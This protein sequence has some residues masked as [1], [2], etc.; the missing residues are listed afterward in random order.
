MKQ[1]PQRLCALC[2]LC[3]CLLAAACDRTIE[4]SA[5]APPRLTLVQSGLRT[6]DL[7]IS[8]RYSLRALQAQVTYDKTALRLT[9]VEPGKE[10]ERMDRVFFT[11]LKKANGAIVVG[12]T[13]TRR[14]LLPARGAL[15]RLHFEPRGSGKGMVKVESPLGALD[16]GQ[17]VGLQGTSLAVTVK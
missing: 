7:Q 6:V 12:I 17:K 14:V 3:G 4:P 16:R 10:A 8:G 9:K 15:I 1:D 2:A 13:D 11:D 5:A